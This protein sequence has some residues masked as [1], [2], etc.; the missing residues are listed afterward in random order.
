MALLVDIG[1]HQQAEKP[2]HHPACALCR[3]A[4]CES[5]VLPLPQEPGVKR[6]LSLRGKVVDL[7]GSLVRLECKCSAL[8]NGQ[9][10]IYQDRPTPCKDYEVGGAACRATVAERR[11]VSA[12][13]IFRLME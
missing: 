4:C 2:D 5:V 11:P 10:S 13:E 12:A 8:V 6:W 7:H 1:E 3:G 9:C